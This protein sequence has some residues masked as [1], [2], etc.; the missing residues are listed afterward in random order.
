MTTQFISEPLYIKKGKRYHIWGGCLSIS[1][2]LDA[3]PLRAN[4]FR[5]TYCVKEGSFRYVYNVRPDFAAFVAAAEIAKE[6][7]IR[8]MMASKYTASMDKIA[9]AGIDAVRNTA[10]AEAATGDKYDIT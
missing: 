3:D 1:E 10:I 2:R 4:T 6:A 9:Q 7:M 5:L 8:A